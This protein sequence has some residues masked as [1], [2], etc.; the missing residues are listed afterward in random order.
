MALAGLVQF[1]S[2]K[3][4]CEVSLLMAAP[5][6]MKSCPPAKAE[7]PGLDRFWIKRSGCMRSHTNLP[8][9]QDITRQDL[10]PPTKN[11]GVFAPGPLLLD[12][13]S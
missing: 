8:V 2:W 11:P 10:T 13:R 12:F 1:R 6:I 7:G 9:L 4:L 3:V 5:L